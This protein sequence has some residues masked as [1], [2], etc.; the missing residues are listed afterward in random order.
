M[1]GL[2]ELVRSF[3][4]NVFVNCFQFLSEVISSD[5]CRI[6]EGVA[7]FPF[8]INCDSTDCD[9]WSIS[10]MQS[11]S[12]GVRTGEIDCDVVVDVQPLFNNCSALHLV[13]LVI[14]EIPIEL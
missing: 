10:T 3:S 11:L 4:S 12:L 7:L 9:F 1:C 5:I 6:T 13:T 8:V 14:G 2:Y